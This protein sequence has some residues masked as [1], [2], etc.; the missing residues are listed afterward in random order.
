[1]TRGGGNLLVAWNNNR[2]ASNSF[3]SNYDPA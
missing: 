2:V 3:F 1:M